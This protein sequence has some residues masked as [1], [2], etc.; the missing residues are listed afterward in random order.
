MNDEQ[1]ILN[2]INDFEDFMENADVE[3]IKK[4]HGLSSSFSLISPKFKEGV[5]SYFN[6]T[7]IR[8]YSIT[9]YNP[10]RNSIDLPLY[11]NDDGYY[12]FL[13][14][15]YI[16]RGSAFDDSSNNIYG[17]LLKEVNSWIISDFPLYPVNGIEPYLDLYYKHNPVVEVVQGEI[18]E[19]PQDIHKRICDN[20]DIVEK[21]L[22]EI[23]VDLK[24]I[25]DNKYY[26]QLGYDTF[27]VYCLECFNIARRTAYR[28]ISIAENLSSE[29]V[30][31]RAQIGVNKLG[32]LSR[33]TDEERTELLEITDIE[34]TPVKQVEQK[35]KEIKNNREVQNNNIVPES[36]EDNSKEIISNNDVSS[37][38]T[39][40]DNN[41]KMVKLDYST[42]E[43]IYKTLMKSRKELLFDNFNK[44]SIIRDLD[45]L[46]NILVKNFP[47]LY[48]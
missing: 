27:E 20:F 26:K 32:V 31:S 40:N 11:Y 16:S 35:A 2:E 33:L 36:F 12:F 38:S 1:L 19:N 14:S 42:I 34:H 21:S 23:C 17:V 46:C 9:I 37:V 47:K 43:F 8:D 44:D 6:I 4:E 22:Y 48:K 39:L 41:V 5:Y 7:N 25:R 24:T 28:Y 30:S 15:K 13:D 3:E 10:H 18:V 45:S 29:F